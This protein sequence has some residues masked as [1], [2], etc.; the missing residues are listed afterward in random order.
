MKASLLRAVLALL[1]VLGTKTPQRS[2]RAEL[3]TS[4]KDP[5]GLWEVRGQDL[6]NGKPVGNARFLRVLKP[7]SRKSAFKACDLWIDFHRTGYE[8]KEKKRKRK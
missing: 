5:Q 3:L 8:N 7:R 4:L 6:V 1:F 2:C